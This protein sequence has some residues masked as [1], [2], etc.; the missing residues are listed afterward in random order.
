MLPTSPHDYGRNVWIF[1][2]ALA[3]A[4]LALLVLVAPT[5]ARSARRSGFE[6]EPLFVT[7]VGTA[8]NPIFNVCA[9]IRNTSDMKQTFDQRYQRGPL[10][11]LLPP[12]SQI[13]ETQEDVDQMLEPGASEL[14]CFRPGFATD[15]LV[16]PE[17]FCHSFEILDPDTGEVIACRT[18]SRLRIPKEPDGESSFGFPVGPGAPA[19]EEELAIMPDVGGLPAGWSV[20]VPELV[21]IPPPGE[22]ITVLVTVTHPADANEGTFLLVFR[23]GGEEEPFGEFEVTVGPVSILPIPVLNHVGFSILVVLLA[24]IGALLARRS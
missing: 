8:E 17:R 11:R 12:N 9:V 23:F 15:E 6:I 20:E 7:N 18:R 13:L 22:E 21:S 1:G 3:A 5:N 10:G 19:G 14:I 4:A 2:W 24:G 16:N